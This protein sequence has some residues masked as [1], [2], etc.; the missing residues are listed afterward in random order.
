MKNVADIYPLTPAQ[1]GILFHTLQA[2]ESG[3][4]FEQ[5]ACTLSGHLDVAAFRQAWRTVVNRHPVLR[6]AFIWEG[7]DEPLQVVRGAIELPFVQEDWRE[8]STAEQH[9]R[10]ETFLRRDRVCGFDP[11]K[12]PLLR[13]A[14][15][16][17]E[18]NVHQ[19]VWSFHHLQLD[20][21]ST[22]LVLKE[23]FDCYEALH[24]DETPKSSASRAFKDY[25]GW[26]KQQDIHQAETFWKKELAGFTTPTA[27]R[28]DSSAT[29]KK[30][31]G[32]YAQC[33]TNLSEPVTA[34]LQKL[35]QQHRFTLN[36]IIQ[37]AWAILLSRYSGERDV[38]FGATVSGRPADLPGVES[39]IGMFINTLPVRIQVEPDVELLPWLKAI[40]SRQLELRCYA[41]SP[42]T[43][44]Q[45]W[46]D[47][48]KGQSLFETI[49]VFENYPI[50][51]SSFQNGNPSLHV[52]NV[53]Y[54]EQSN[55]PLSVL[56]V[57]GSE[58]V[59][60]IIYDRAWF[61]DDAVPRIL[62]HLETVL[63]GMASH[64]TRPLSDIPLLTAQE[65]HQLTVEWNDTR[66]D[67]PRVTCIHQLIEEQAAQNPTAIAVHLG[68]QQL[69]YGELDGRANRLAHHLCA[70]GVA[71]GDLVGICLERSLEIIVALVGVLKTGA[72]YVP[73]DPTY[74]QA[75]LAFM[76]AETQAPVLLTQQYLA[77]RLPHHTGQVICLDTHWPTIAQQ[78]DQKPASDASAEDLVYVIYTSG[79]TGKPKGVQITHSN[80][81]NSTQARLDYY[82]EPVSSFLLL[83]SFAFDSSMVGIFGTLCQGGTLI[84]PAPGDEQDVQKLAGLIDRHQITDTLCLPSLYNLILTYAQAH[85][86]DSLKTVIVAG[87]ACPQE[88]IQRHYQRLPQTALYNEYG[89]TEA[90]VWS[91]VYQVL[92]TDVETPVPIGRPIA[93]TQVFIL[94]KH[95]QPVPIGVPGELYIGGDGLA[96]GYLNQPELTAESFIPS[97][98]QDE[99]NSRLYKTGDLARYL[100]DGNIQFLG[101]V[102]HQVKIRGYRVELDEIQLALSQHPQI[103]ENVVVAWESERGQQLAAYFVPAS[104][105]VPRS[106]KLRSF[107][108]AKLPDYMLPMAFICLEAVPVTP[109]GKVDRRSLPR[110]DQVSEDEEDAFVPPHTDTEATI[111][112]IWGELLGLNRVGRH[113]DFFSLGGHSLLV[114]QLV[115][116]LRNVFKVQLPVNSVFEKPTLAGTA[117]QIETL[118]WAK[119]TNQQRTGFKTDGD[120]EEFEI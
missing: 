15:F 70:Q 87:E 49:V 119:H 39:M 7:I 34:T 64:P 45:A 31:T 66:T 30:P 18:T 62:G 44:I 90:T 32:S 13:L 29:V 41:Y 89:P 8:F 46:S 108:Q 77:G 56:A 24:R 57:P 27:L 114:M 40:Q 86:L 11:A 105:L 84:L 115:A 26:L 116:R 98:F 53:R 25:V 78:S 23:V 2:P 92:A 51:G 97:P 71:P 102:D 100:P 63:S 112:Q 21:W 36:T 69:S 111:A 99:S 110:P 72:A 1:A 19:M 52:E 93:N 43:K 109:N 10:L 67:Y 75:R 38:L 107:L 35:A 96:G 81:I 4:Y 28:V 58:L 60:H 74:P 103:R 59:I 118:L 104:E 101:R 117:E 95:H 20:G 54:L 6:T 17:V 5:Y 14:L 9:D 113:E 16:Q 42:L 61:D 33:Q 120:R 94:D 37:G 79:S 82:P 76:L 12:A 106:E 65:R 85:Q 91:T 22:A 88:I 47:I 80:L 68:D 48:P 83:S 50:D 73:L 3:V 55:Y